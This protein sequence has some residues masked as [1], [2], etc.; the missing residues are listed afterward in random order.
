[1]TTGTRIARSLG[2]NKAAILR[3]HGLLTVGGTVEAAVWWFI[4]ME[5][6]CQAQFLA[7]LVGKPLVVDPIEARATKAVNG[8]PVAGWFNYQPL[9][10]KIVK[11]QPDLLD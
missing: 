9:W 1:M 4:A 5:R 10:D 7:E 8:T 2:A 3:N 11:E 6:C